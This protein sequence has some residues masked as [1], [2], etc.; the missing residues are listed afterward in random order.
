MNTHKQSF[1]WILDAGLLL[2]FLL[3]FF[4]NLTGLDLHQ[5]LGVGLG[6]FAGY[7]LLRHWD[8]VRAVTA[9]FFSST[10]PRVLAYYTLDAALLL[11]FGLIVST[12][13]AIS[14][15]LSLAAGIYS[16]WKNLHVY[17]SVITLLLVVLKIGL[18]WRWIVKTASRIFQAGQDAPARPQPRAAL[19]SAPAAI[20][21][22]HFLALMGVVGVAAWAAVGNVF[23]DQQT[24]QA[25]A[26]SSSATGTSGTTAASSAASTTSNIP[27]S[28][29][30]CA[31][32]CD[33]HCSYPGRCRRYTDIKGNGKCD[34]S[35]C[36]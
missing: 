35:E 14:N 23:T 36:V 13:I 31:L 25:E 19:A 7:H 29:T 1:N 30:S 32:R 21:R 24:V 16:V 22:R 28:T 15:W 2:G 12:G 18:H 4:L 17:A 33:K 8:W 11:G 20:N 9:K 5:W 34:L 26:L 3:A 10:S 6:V 27:N